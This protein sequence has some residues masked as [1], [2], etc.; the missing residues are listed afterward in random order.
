MKAR[1]LQYADL[2]PDLTDKLAKYLEWKLPELEK[3]EI[4]KQEYLEIAE[5]YEEYENI[6][7][8]LSVFNLS[9]QYTVFLFLTHQAPRQNINTVNSRATRYGR[10]LVGHLKI[11]R[12]FLCVCVVY[13]TIIYIIYILGSISRT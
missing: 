7:A 4:A 10:R 3:G 1:L 2:P 12:F 6:E 5:N 13:A 8:V 9:F 11:A